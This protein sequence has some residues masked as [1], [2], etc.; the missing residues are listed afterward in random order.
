[1]T[2]EVDC[3]TVAH[4][5]SVH[6]DEHQERDQALRCIF[7]GFHRGTDLIRRVA[8][9]LLQTVLTRTYLSS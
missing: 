2:M 4:L 3:E 8:S 1:M 6:Q 7:L 5:R 9:E